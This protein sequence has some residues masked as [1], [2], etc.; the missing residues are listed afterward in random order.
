M[1]QINIQRKEYSGDT[2]FRNARLR[3]KESQ[4][5]N[6]LTGPSGCGKTTLLNMLY[7]LDQAFEGEYIFFGENTKTMSQRKWRQVWREDMAIVFQDFKLLPFL[8]VY[9]TLYYAL[10]DDENAQE[11][12][13]EILDVVNL[14]K[15]TSKLPSELSGGQKQLLSIARSMVNH[16]KFLLIDE[17]TANLS[18]K[19][20][21]KFSQILDWFRQSD[22]IVL[23]AT[24]E[25]KLIEHADQVFTIHKKLINKGIAVK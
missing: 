7:G 3:I 21:G 5:I 1:I 10:R 19:F 24:H 2:I 11:R 4:K 15:M 12:I 18:G 14:S 6:V 9:D 8:T 25:Q 13:M 20:I 23:I 16:P 17:P 22:T